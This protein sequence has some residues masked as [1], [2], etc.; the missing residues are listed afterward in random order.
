MR[1]DE[2]LYLLPLKR[3]NA[4]GEEFDAEDDDRDRF[5]GPPFELPLILMVGACYNICVVG[6]LIEFS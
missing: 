2:G 6:S 4:E 1:R 5:R 3:W